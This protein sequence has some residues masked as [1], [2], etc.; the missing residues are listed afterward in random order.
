MFTV[1]LSMKFDRSVVIVLCRL[2]PWKQLVLTVF[3][4]MKFD[5]SVVYCVV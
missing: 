4:R 5:R 2:L 3:L 1:F